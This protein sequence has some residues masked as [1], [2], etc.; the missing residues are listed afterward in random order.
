[1]GLYEGDRVCWN[2]YY[3]STFVFVTGC[4]KVE[5]D[6]TQALSYCSPIEKLCN[7]GHEEAP[8]G[9]CLEPQKRCCRTAC[10]GPG[11]YCLTEQAPCY[12]EDEEVAGK[13]PVDGFRCCR[14]SGVRKSK[15]ILDIF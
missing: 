7:P 1:M 12:P 9:L 6:Q 10:S 3:F 13:C 11:S 4:T 14:P 15:R 5:C 2:R 8:H